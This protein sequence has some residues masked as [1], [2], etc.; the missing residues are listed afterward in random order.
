ML[1]FVAAVAHPGRA[2]PAHVAERLAKGRAPLPFDATDEHRW[3]NPEGSV[4]V[5]A[6]ESPSPAL[7]IRTRWRADPDGLTAYAGHAWIRHRGADPDGRSLHELCRACPPDRCGDV[8]AGVYSILSVDGAGRGW[9]MSDPLGLDLLYRGEVDSCCTVLASRADAAAWALADPGAEP[10]RDPLGVAWLGYTGYLVGDRTGFRGVTTVPAGTAVELGPEG[11]ARDRTWWCP[12][13]ADTIEPAPVEEW[14][15]AVRAD[16]A[17]HLRLA[18]ALAGPGTFADLTGGKDSRLVL[19]VLLDAGLAGDVRFRTLGDHGVEDI[20]IAREIAAELGLRHDAGVAGPRSPLGYEA[21]ARAFVN[22]TSGAMSVW[23]QAPLVA[24]DALHLSG[25]CGEILR[26]H[27]PRT[28]DLR[29]WDQLAH[30]FRNGWRFGSGGFLH[31]DARRLLEAEAREAVFDDA[32]AHLSPVDAVDVFFLRHRLRRWTGGAHEVDRTNRVFPL[33]SPTLLRA[34]FAVG[35]AARRAELLHHAVV[36]AC[37]PTLAS[38]RLAGDSWALHLADEPWP[39]SDVDANAEA[40]ARARSSVPD[41]PPEP[42]PRRAT[43]RTARQRI[44]LR[45]LHE[46]RDVLGSFVAADPA[47]PAFEV[48]DRERLLTGLERLDQLGLHERQQLY[49]AVTGVL[50][51]GG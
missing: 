35:D 30:R 24:T 3:A 9:V 37:C 39:R 16:I 48:F 42:S 43:M 2:V 14:V 23:D 51:L 47:N 13:W 12:P 46:E 18:T 10:A 49:G 4:L 7:G 38:W 29:T 25:L 27:F 11:G 32:L 5:A 17:E 50:W 36:S 22:A 21:R 6:W 31:E 44:H 45:S 41:A 34:G 15:E 20:E 19:A 8:L 28:G 33:Y 26:T 1:T 40:I